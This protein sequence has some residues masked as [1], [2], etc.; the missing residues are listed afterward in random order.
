V[1]ELSLVLAL[2]ASPLQLLGMFL[3]K[4]RGCLETTMLLLSGSLFY[5][6][7][8]PKKRSC[9]GEKGA[10]E[11]KEDETWKNE[12][13][14][15]EEGEGGGWEQERGTRTRTRWEKIVRCSGEGFQCR[16][17]CVFFWLY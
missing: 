10:A 16:I 12:G 17:A 5:S 9:N 11:Q 2:L 14:E 6:Y 8:G 13:T 15:T 4:K 1:V 3:T 7:L